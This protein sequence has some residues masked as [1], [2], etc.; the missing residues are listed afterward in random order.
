MLGCKAKIENEEFRKL[1]SEMGMRITPITLQRR[2]RLRV[3]DY[4]KK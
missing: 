1:S 3:E 4:E 2:D